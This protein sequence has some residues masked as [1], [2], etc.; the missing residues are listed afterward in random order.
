MLFL[1]RSFMGCDSVQHAEPSGASVV[2]Q[3]C[4]EGCY[5][6]HEGG[7]GRGRKGMGQES[8]GAWGWIRAA[9]SHGFGNLAPTLLAIGL[10]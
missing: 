10:A 9:S 5:A 6:L 2:H 7:E 8:R 4:L 3:A 1:H